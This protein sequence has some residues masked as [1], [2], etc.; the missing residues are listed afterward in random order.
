MV[1]TQI[2]LDSAAYQLVKN[3]AYSE[4]RSMAAVIR[5]AV[6]AYLDAPKNPKR[7]LKLTD[8]SC[9]GIASAEHSEARPLSVYH[10]EIWDVDWRD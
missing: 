2:Q 4:K 9:I 7:K 3:R 8:F 1:R 10:D 6:D 5:D